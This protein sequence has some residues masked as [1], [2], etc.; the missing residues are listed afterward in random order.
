MKNYNHLFSEMLTANKNE[1]RLAAPKYFETTTKN[2]GNK[3]NKFGI[4]F[5]IFEKRSVIILKI[6]FQRYSQ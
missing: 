5:S 6:I 4:Y 1:Q 2:D 3:I